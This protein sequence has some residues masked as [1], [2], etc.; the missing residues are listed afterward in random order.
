MLA[1]VVTAQ[2]AN[3]QTARNKKNREREQNAAE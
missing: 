1:F 2:R 3:K